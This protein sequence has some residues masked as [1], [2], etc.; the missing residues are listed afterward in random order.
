MKRV[1]VAFFLAAMALACAG[2]GTPAAKE[3]ILGRTT[4]RAD[5]AAKVTRA[6]V[7][8]A[9]EVTIVLRP[10]RTPGYVWQIAQHNSAALRQKTEVAT[11]PAGETTVAFLTLRTGLTRIMFAL[12]PPNGPAEAEP[13]DVEDVQLTIE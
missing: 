2:C 1:L 10:P 4:V 8:L 7:K 6:T 11:N 13:A 9:H 3:V 12:V 5:S